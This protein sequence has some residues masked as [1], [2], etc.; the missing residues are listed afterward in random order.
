MGNNVVRPS[1]VVLLVVTLLALGL[2]SCKKSGK[3]TNSDKLSSAQKISELPTQV[4]EDTMAPPTNIRARNV[5]GQKRVDLGG[6]NSLSRYVSYIE[7]AWD[8]I[9]GAAS[10]TLYW[11]RSPNV[12]KAAATT[13]TNVTPPYE[14]D[15]QIHDGRLYYR[16]AAVNAGAESELSAEVSVEAPSGFVRF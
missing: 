13:I 5:S 8:P 15:I 10:Y 14:H 2:S 12:T 7:V 4:R 1:V 11:S 6:G 3:A 9:P 16:V